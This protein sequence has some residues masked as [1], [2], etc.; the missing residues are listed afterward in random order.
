MIIPSKKILVI[1]CFTDS[2]LA[3]S[4]EDSIHNIIKKEKLNIPTSFVKAMNSHTVSSGNFDA[5][6]IS[7]SEQN[8]IDNHP[9]FESLEQLIASFDKQSKPVLGICFGH[10]FLAK[11]YGDDNIITRMTKAE[12]GWNKIKM[13]EDIL[14]HGITSHMFMTSHFFEVDKV[15]EDFIS[16]ASSDQCSI[17]AIR[18][19]TNPIWGIQFHPEYNLEKAVEIFNFLK[20]HYSINLPELIQAKT[21]QHNHKILTNFFNII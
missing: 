13:K 2:Q 15:P 21:I 3:Y 12:I 19:K 11:V 1:N 16:L 9:W 6:I 17:Q 4:F 20:Q 14:F 7:G 8:I 5:L 18:H 10:Q